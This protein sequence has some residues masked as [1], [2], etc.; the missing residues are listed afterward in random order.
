VAT[1]IRLRTEILADP[2][3]AWDE[4]EAG[5]TFLEE[6]IH[7]QSPSYTVTPFVPGTRT[8]TW[9]MTKSEIQGLEDRMHA[10]SVFLGIPHLLTTWSGLMPVGYNA[11][12]H[13]IL[14]LKPEEWIDYG[15]DLD[16]Y[17]GDIMPF[18]YNL[19]GIDWLAMFRG[20]ISTDPLTDLIASKFAK[21]YENFDSTGTI[22][23]PAVFNSAR[24][25]EIVVAALDATHAIIV[26]RDYGNSNKGTARIATNTDG[27]V[28]YGAEFVFNNSGTYTPSV[29]AIDAT[30]AIIVFSDAGDSYYG[31]AI[32]ATIDNESIS[33]NVALSFHDDQT[34][35]P[36]VS[37]IDAAHYLISYSCNKVLAADSYA[38]AV[39]GTIA[40]GVIS[41]GSTA[42]FLNA[43][44]SLYT[45]NVALSTT[46]AIVMYSD[47]GNSTYGTAKPIVIS[48]SSLSF[49]TA[50]V[51]ESDYTY[52]NAAGKIDG[53]K[54]LTAF[55]GADSYV[56]VATITDGVLS[57]GTKQVIL[58]SATAFSISM[59][60]STHAFV[61]CKSSSNPYVSV[62]I[63]DGNALTVKS[64]MVENTTAYATAV[65]TLDSANAIVCYQDYYNSRYGEAAIAT[66]A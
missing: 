60:D 28:T 19:P 66:V 25:E 4:L 48:G 59:I 49:G 12:N 45:T 18:G 57:F 20:E 32:I 52:N 5:I 44:N 2:I 13:F 3:T 58:S 11:M 37:M 27:V 42:R 7:A 15:F 26:Y 46:Q 41:F 50:V 16:G 61:A 14:G 9:V 22:G 24:T 10:V 43:A 63:I 39:V 65:A 36:V 40:D 34:D 21:D 35:Y 33:F 17:L 54:A 1:P 6:E 8:S 64:K 47:Q 53:N 55:F 29:T 30:R 31:K 38:E 23:T 62:I 56:C 51:F